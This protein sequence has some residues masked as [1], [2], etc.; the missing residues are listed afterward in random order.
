MLV[1]AKIKTAKISTGELKIILYHIAARQRIDQSCINSYK[2]QTEEI[3][4][5]GF[6]WS[7]GERL[8]SLQGELGHCSWRINAMFEGGWQLVKISWNVKSREAWHEKGMV[9]CCSPA[10]CKCE[11]KKSQKFILKRIQHFHEIWKYPTV[12][13][14]QLNNTLPL[15]MILSLFIC[16]HTQ[17]TAGMGTEGSQWCTTDTPSPPRFSS[18]TLLRPSRSMPSPHRRKRTVCELVSFSNPVVSVG[19]GMTPFH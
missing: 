7:D 14:P 18:R 13:H 17:W 4:F 1:N 9:N 15:K 10:C 11:I 2:E 8:P 6:C 16:T 5:I 3:G 19:I 12:L